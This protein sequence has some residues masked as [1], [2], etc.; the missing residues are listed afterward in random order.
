LINISILLNILFADSEIQKKFDLPSS[1]RV[2]LFDYNLFNNNPKVFDSTNYEFSFKTNLSRTLKLHSITLVFNNKNR[3]K[4]Y[5]SDD[6]TVSK[7]STLQLGYNILVKPS[8]DQLKL[9]K[10]RYE[11]HPE[12]TKNLLIFENNIVNESKKT[13]QL[14]YTK[15]NIIEFLFAKKILMSSNQYFKFDF[16]VIKK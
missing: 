12:N 16:S 9:L 15:L 8:D 6:L 11:L 14:K 5:L 7:D 2:F 3:N 4:Q 1:N 13:V 10:V